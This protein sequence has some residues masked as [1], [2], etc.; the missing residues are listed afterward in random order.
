MIKL[1]NETRECCQ[2]LVSCLGLDIIC[3]NV[4]FGSIEEDRKTSSTNGDG[5]NLLQF[6]TLL[7]TVA[8][9]INIVEVDTNHADMM[10]SVKFSPN[11]LR[12]NNCFPKCACKHK[13]PAINLLIQS[14]T[15]QTSQPE[16]QASPIFT[17]NSTTCTFLVINVNFYI[18]IL[19]A[20]RLMSLH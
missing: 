9:L 15:Q 20:N 1:S 8:L 5:F 3:R 7:L 17:V 2:R 19:S 18:S 11:C 10:R 13:V 4:V 12:I 6:E 16:S 14:F